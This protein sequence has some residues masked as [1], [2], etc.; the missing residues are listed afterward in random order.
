MVHA[1]GKEKSSSKYAFS[2]KYVTNLYAKDSTLND[3]L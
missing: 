2:P 3:K 1:I